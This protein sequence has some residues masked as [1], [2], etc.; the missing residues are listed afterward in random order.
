MVPREILFRGQVEDAG[1]LDLDSLVRE[2]RNLREDLE[3]LKRRKGGDGGPPKRTNGDRLLWDRVWDILKWA[4]IPWVLWVSIQLLG[5]TGTRF[6]DLDGAQLEQRVE[7]RLQEHERENGH[8]AMI[9]RMEAV[10]LRLQ[11]IE[12][13]N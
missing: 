7:E 4:I 10:M 9:A 2:L 13:G 6:T 12:N 8:A 1:P 5:V 11:A 3:P